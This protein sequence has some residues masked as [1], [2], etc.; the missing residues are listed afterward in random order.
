MGDLIDLEQGQNL[1]QIHKRKIAKSEISQFPTKRKAVF[2]AVGEEK[3]MLNIFTD[4]S[5]A[6]CKKLHKEVPKSQ[7]AGISVH[8]IPYPRGGNR[9]PGYQ[10]L[11][12]VWC[13]K[14]RATALTIGKG[15]TP[16]ELPVG[17]CED[18]I[19]VDQGHMLG[20]QVGVTG[21]P[22]LFKLNGEMITGYVPYNKLIPM[23]LNN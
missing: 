23:I 17:D 3:A 14:D 2:Q 16:S 21:T 22:A 20:N 9:G 19:L 18:G 1:T 12:Q 8:Y 7:D 10:K 4:T 5:C 13:A 15:L 6:Y 11:K